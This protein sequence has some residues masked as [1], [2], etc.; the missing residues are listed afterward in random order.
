MLGTARA[1][2]YDVLVQC[3]YENGKGWIK[4]PARQRGRA[5]EKGFLVHCVHFQK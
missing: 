2:K 5:E 4:Y 3:R 1:L